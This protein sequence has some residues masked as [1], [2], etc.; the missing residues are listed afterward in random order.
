MPL[1]IKLEDG[2]LII[3]AGDGGNGQ[4]VKDAT[5][6]LAMIQRAADIPVRG[7][8]NKGKTLRYHNVVRQMMP[9]GMWSGKALTIRLD[10]DTLK[11]PDTDSAA[12]LIQSGMAGPILGAVM[13][14]QL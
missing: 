11:L 12:I 2:R 5:I 1:T 10:R 9:V 13:I 4:N 6:W 14:P 8:E 7:G 3:E